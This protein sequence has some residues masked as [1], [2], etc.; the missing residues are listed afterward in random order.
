MII[1][2]QTKIDKTRAEIHRFIKK[3][4]QGEIEYEFDSHKGFTFTKGD[5]YTKGSEFY[6]KEKFLGFFIKLRFTVTGFTKTQFK[7]ILKNFPV[8][9]KFI[10]KNKTLGLVINLPWYMFLLKPLIQKQIDKE[11]VFLKQ[12]LFSN[13]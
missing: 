2:A 5:I 8:T 3:L 11:I 13:L 9:G 10:F 1:K 12:A 4:S 6:T 7:F